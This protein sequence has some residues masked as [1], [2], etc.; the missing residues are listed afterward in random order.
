MYFTLIS[1]IELVGDQ[2]CFSKSLVLVYSVIVFVVCG[3]LSCIKSS[4]YYVL[5][6]D[7]LIYSVT[8]FELSSNTCY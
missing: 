6:S 4:F 5:V 3:K 7:T 2:T 1:N 8:G